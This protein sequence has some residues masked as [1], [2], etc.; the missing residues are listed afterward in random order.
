VLIRVL[1]HEER[2]RAVRGEVGEVA[3][4]RVGVDLARRRT[5]D[6]LEEDAR[7]LVAGGVRAVPEEVGLAARDV[8]RVAMELL[9]GRE[10]FE[11]LAVH[12]DTP[13]VEVPVRAGVAREEHGAFVGRQY[14]PA[15]ALVRGGKPA[16]GRRRVRRVRRIELRQSVA[17]RREDEDAGAGE[18]SP[19]VA[20]RLEER[21]R[22]GHRDASRAACSAVSAG[23][24]LSATSA[25]F[26]GADGGAATGA[27]GGDAI[28]A[29]GSHDASKSAENISR[30]FRTMTRP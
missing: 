28:V 22:R 9:A 26:T 20:E 3:A 10:V 15:G 11:P 24:A 18:S 2:L 21:A 19:R 5:V 23:R 17:R 27:T 30:A 14:D 12:A 4:A 13:D 6:A 1:P 25:G 7:L 29:S 8:G 16:R